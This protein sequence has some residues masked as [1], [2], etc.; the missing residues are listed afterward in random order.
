MSETIVLPR[1]GSFARKGEYTGPGLGRGI[2]RWASPAAL[3]HELG[4]AMCPAMEA[5]Q[6]AEKAAWEALWAAP[7]VANLNESARRAL[8]A[9]EAKSSAAYSRAEANAKARDEEK[10]EA[11]RLRLNAAIR[12]AIK[13][14]KAP[15][16]PKAKKRA[17][18]KAAVAEPIAEAKVEKVRAAISRAAAP[19]AVDE[20]IEPVEEVIEPVAEPEVMA[21]VVA[22]VE[23][24]VVA[25][26]EVKRPRKPARKGR[27]KAKAARKA[28]KA[29]A[30]AARKAA[31]AEKAKAKADAKA[32]AN[33]HALPPQG[34]RTRRRVAKNAPVSLPANTAKAA[35]KAKAA[36]AAEAQ[37]RATE[38][39]I[40]RAAKRAIKRAAKRAAKRALV[41][42]Q[43]MAVRKAAKAKAKAEKAARRAAIE[44]MN[45]EE[46]FKAVL[47]RHGAAPQNIFEAR[48]IAK[49]NLL[50]AGEKLLSA[51]ENLARWGLRNEGFAT[52]ILMNFATERLASERPIAKREKTL[53]KA[54][55]AHMGAGVKRGGTPAARREWEAFEAIVQHLQAQGSHVTVKVENNLAVRSFGGAL[56]NAQTNEVMGLPYPLAL[57]H[58][59]GHAASTA[60]VTKAMVGHM[61]GQLT[62]TLDIEL[63]ADEKAI[64]LL[65][66]LG[67]GDLVPSYMG[68]RQASTAYYHLMAKRWIRSRAIF[69]RWANHGAAPIHV[70]TNGRGEDMGVV[71]EMEAGLL[72][73]SFEAMGQEG[74]V[75]YWDLGLVL[76]PH[77]L[78]VDGAIDLSMDP[79]RLETL[80]A[81]SNGGLS[82][83]EETKRVIPL[84]FAEGMRALTGC[85][86]REKTL[87]VTAVGMDEKRR[88]RYR[89]AL[90]PV[91]FVRLWDEDDDEV[92]VMA[93]QTKNFKGKT[94]TEKE[95]LERL[96]RSGLFSRHGA[97][98]R[99]VTGA[100][101]LD[102]EQKEKLLVVGL[103]YGTVITAAVSVEGLVLGLFAELTSFPA[104]GI[105][106]LALG[107]AI[108]GEED[109][110]KSGADLLFAVDRAV[111]GAVAGGAQLRAISKGLKA[112]KAAF[113]EGMKGILSKL[114]EIRI[115]PA[116]GVAIDVVGVDNRRDFIYDRLFGRRGFSWRDGGI[117]AVLPI[118]WWG[119]ALDADISHKNPSRVWEGV[120]GAQLGNEVT[121]LNAD[122]VDFYTSEDDS[123]KEQ[124]LE[125]AMRSR[126][127]RLTHGALPITPSLR[128]NDPAWEEACEAMAFIAMKAGRLKSLEIV[129][130]HDEG[131]HFDAETLTAEGLT[132]LVLCHEIGHAMTWEGP[133][134]AWSGAECPDTS[135]Y[136]LEV[137][138]DKWVVRFLNETGREGMVPQYWLA[139]QRPMSNYLLHAKNAVSE[140][141]KMFKKADLDALKTL[142]ASL[143]MGHNIQ[144]RAAAIEIA[145]ARLGMDIAQED[146]S[147]LAQLK[148]PGVVSG[149]FIS[150]LM[151]RHGALPPHLDRGD[152]PRP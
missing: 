123:E 113:I 30:E 142:K 129:P 65:S 114:D 55:K 106:N 84:L 49:E 76:A 91:G 89:A 86:T 99:V 150:A 136:A 9:F 128:E 62:A 147:V 11:R 3:L 95:V 24:E 81:N 71:A 96:I 103:D 131:G 54:M 28:A 61:R 34:Q 94:V 110:E 92:M 70:R 90:A 112:L 100:V 43:V 41:G 139:R 138:A 51:R 152:G 16:A 146:V 132:H 108:L 10:A 79:W 32:K 39:A 1:E 75:Q 93:C 77:K 2:V 27:R 47:A 58:E 120:F 35:K 37:E 148:T 151:A 12:R 60:L 50:K 137:E 7:E 42:T 53:V 117:T 134:F 133:V 66:E 97:A 107:A 6:A 36:A 67:Y 127:M 111:A 5:G 130:E 20:V 102:D 125:K 48:E 69:V 115:E 87:V 44:A 31:K 135:I 121:Q 52:S 45:S 18:A 140:V 56:Y 8:K 63:A 83:G 13:A 64:E 57:I 101:V 88:A 26:V 80:V 59:L 38:R 29:K 122:L 23:V 104:M 33:A 118:G 21:E 145:V 74:G 105:E 46:V 85:L 149:V 40:E 82:G 73:L 25:E 14:P 124:A 17:A 72:A 119:V 144:E 19:K 116:L 22:E 78:G 4:H 141:E 15:K 143:S 98:P 68:Y 109:A 126:L